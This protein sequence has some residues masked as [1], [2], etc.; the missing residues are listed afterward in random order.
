MIKWKNG[1][2][3]RQTQLY[4]IVPYCE[5]NLIIMALKSKLRHFDGMKWV[6]MRIGHFFGFFFHHSLSKIEME[7]TFRI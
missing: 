2:G 5:Q 4:Y 7:R 6:W 1:S 3:N